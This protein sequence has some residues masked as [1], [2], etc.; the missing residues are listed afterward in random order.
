MRF[1]RRF[2]LPFAVIVIAAAL[3]T[4]VLGRVQVAASSSAMANP[5]MKLTASSSLT[6]AGQIAAGHLL[7]TETCSTRCA[8]RRRCSA[9]CFT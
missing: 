1:L 9:C 8:P 2:L 4:F 3:G 5:G 7:F 6:N